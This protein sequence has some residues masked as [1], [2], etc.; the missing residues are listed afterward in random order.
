MRLSLSVEAVPGEDLGLVLYEA[1]ARKDLLESV[2][3]VPIE[4][5]EA[6]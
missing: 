4:V 5:V 6:A 1:D 3:D 2:L